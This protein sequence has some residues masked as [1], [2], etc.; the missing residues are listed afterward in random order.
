MVHLMAV[1]A[2]KDLTAM[3]VLA[4]GDPEAKV[5]ARRVAREHMIKTLAEWLGPPDAEARAIDAVGD[6]ALR[7]L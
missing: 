6:D 5:I 3:L 7:H 1:Q 2:D 4:A